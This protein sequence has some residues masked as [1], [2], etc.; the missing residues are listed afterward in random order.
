MGVKIDPN[1]PNKNTT[2]RILQT[3]QSS[4]VRIFLTYFSANRSEIKQNPQNQIL[5][6]TDGHKYPGTVLT[7][8][9][10]RTRSGGACEYMCVAAMHAP[11]PC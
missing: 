9:A 5:I 4:T 1:I 7:S 2:S 6:S 11:R 3:A 8:D 10:R